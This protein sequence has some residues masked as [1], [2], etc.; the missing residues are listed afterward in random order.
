MDSAAAYVEGMNGPDH[1]KLAQAATAARK[2]ALA[3]AP[4]EIKDD[5]RITAALAGSAQAGLENTA[6]EIPIKPQTPEQI[7]KAVGAWKTWTEKNCSA[8]VAARWKV[9]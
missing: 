3:S 7:K 9:T 1:T 2:V 4:S 5:V 8:E 6:E